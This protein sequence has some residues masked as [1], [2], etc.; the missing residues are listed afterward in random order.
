MAQNIKTGRQRMIASSFTEKNLSKEMKA[1][2]RLMQEGLRAAI[3]KAERFGT[4]LVIKEN[5][6]IKHLT[7]AE[8]RARLEK[9]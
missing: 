7:P 9:K 6:K 1:D 3:E 4:S 8:M 5:G 2:I